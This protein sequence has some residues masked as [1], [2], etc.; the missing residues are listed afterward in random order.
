MTTKPL[1]V[2]PI[3]PRFV[4]EGDRLAFPVKVTNR[5][6]VPQTG[7]ATLDFFDAATDKPRVLGGGAT[8]QA[9]TLGPNESKTLMFDLVIPDGCPDLR[10]VAAA[11][12]ENFSDGEEGKLPV[13]SKRLLVRA[14]L[15]IQIVQAGMKTAT[16]K[17][18]AASAASPTLKH[19]E[20]AVDIVGD[21]AWHAFLALPSL[22]ESS[23]ESLERVFSRFYANEVAQHLVRSRPDFKTAVKRVF[24][25]QFESRRFALEQLKQLEQNI[26]EDGEEGYLWPWFPGGP[27]DTWVSMYILTGFARLDRLAGDSTRVP[28]PDDM[29]LVQNGVNGAMARHVEVRKAVCRQRKTEFVP[30]SLE[31]HWLYLLSFTGTKADPAPF[32]LARLR[33]T[34]TRLDLAGTALAA[35]VLARQPAK[36]DRTLARTMVQSLKERAVRSEEFGLF[37]KRAHDFGG[38]PFA[39]S[40]SDQTLAMEAFLEVTPEDVASYKAARQWLLEQKRTQNW[41]T[42]VSTVDAIYAILRGVGSA[43]STTKNDDVVKVSLGGVEVP[44]K[45]VETDTGFYECRVPREQITAKL[46]EVAVSRKTDALGWV[47]VNWTYLEDAAKVRA[48]EQA[49]LGVTKTYYKKARLDGKECLVALNGGEVLEPGD[50]LVARLVLDSNRLYEY[51]HLRDERPATAEPVDVQSHYRWQGGL[52]FYQATGDTAMDYYIDQLPQGRFVLE[53]SY[54]VRERGT[55]TSGLA[56][57]QCLYAPEFGAHSAT[58][59]LTVK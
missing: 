3:A 7:T 56:S 32:L 12:G 55:F 4:R 16:F 15:P 51:V 27:K 42:S 35:I 40:V 59:T 39:T 34:W 18:L 29:E 45:A 5:E 19:V 14:S 38:S 54:R 48:F 20:L 17:E 44:R 30:D 13:L 50:E 33:E 26:K 28:K 57:V 22:K 9:F 47:S 58:T 49:G 25:D 23:H 8:S 6:N 1:M 53:T 21:P 24:G 52:G 36:D 43:A 2:E 37:W 31:L 10:Y 11:K 41:P 46:G